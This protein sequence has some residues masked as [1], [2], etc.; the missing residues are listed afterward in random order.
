MSAEVANAA[1]LR[2]EGRWDDAL[3]ELDGIETRDALLERME[4]LSDQNLFVRDRRAEMED[5]L[6][7]LSDLAKAT[8]DPALE[9]FVL[10]RGAFALHAEFLANPDAGEPPKEMSLLVRALAIRQSLADRRGVAESLFLLGLVQQIERQAGPAARVFFK[11][12]YAIAREVGDIV[13]MSYAVRHL[14][15]LEQAA[16]RLTD[17]QRAFEESLAL[18]EE[19]GWRPGIAAAQLDLASVLAAKG[20]RATARALATSA[21]QVLSELRCERFHG[22]VAEEIHELT[23]VD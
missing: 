20:D 23:A 14:G 4:I 12:S 1:R 22:L 5:V 15:Y 2:L 10:S 19:A 3:G 13:L 21:D 6:Q 11:R 18:R 8:R 9:A 16:G 17:A 7:Q